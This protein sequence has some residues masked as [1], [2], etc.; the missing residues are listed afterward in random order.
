MNTL[1][2]LDLLPTLEVVKDYD[3]VTE[4]P[5][6]DKKTGQ[7]K[8]IFKQNVYL[9]N[10]GAFPV[11]FSINIKDKNQPLPVGSYII[12]KQCYVISGQF[13]QLNIDSRDIQDHLI[14]LTNLKLA[15]VS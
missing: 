15:K 7:P 13:N 1:E 14:P 12:P 9:S 8:T 2:L 11:Q 5:Y 4:I 10:G 6:T 3:Q